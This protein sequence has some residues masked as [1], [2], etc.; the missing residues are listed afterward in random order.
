MFEDLRQASDDVRELAGWQKA[1]IRR[2]VQSGSSGVGIPPTDAY[3][4]GLADLPVIATLRPTGLDEGPI[5][6]T[7]EAAVQFEF[8]NVE[9][10]PGDEV[11]F[12]DET[13]EVESVASRSPSLVLGA[14]KT[15]GG[16]VVLES[17]DAPEEPVAAMCLVTTKPAG[18]VSFRLEYID[19]NNE[20]RLSDAISFAG[21]CK[22]GDCRTVTTDGDRCLV[23][24]L[25]G[26]K[27]FSGQLGGGVLTIMDDCPFRVRVLAARKSVDG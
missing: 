21:D 12:E 2:L 9:V 5:A 1:S 8:W 15:Q 18:N 16:S 27:E 13:Y 3:A 23:A 20:T 25:S 19:D 17:A 10:G 4:S 24:S 22:V 6:S 26:I 7:T 14:V 11:V